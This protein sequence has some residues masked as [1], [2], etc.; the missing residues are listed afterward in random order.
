MPF[1]F[2]QQVHRRSCFCLTPFVKS[3][4]YLQMHQ[5]ISSNMHIS[6][7]VCIKQHTPFTPMYS[8]QCASITNSK[9]FI[10]SLFGFEANCHMSMGGLSISSLCDKHRHYLIGLKVVSIIVRIG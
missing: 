4:I 1:A 9:H 8:V 2:S 7:A 3:W 6:S 10:C 5:S